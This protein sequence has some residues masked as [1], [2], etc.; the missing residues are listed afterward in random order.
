MLTLLSL[1]L[2]HYSSAEYQMCSW[3][4]EWKCPMA[5]ASLEVLTNSESIQ[6]QIDLLV[7]D[8]CPQ[9]TIMT[10]E[11]CVERLPDFWRSA[12]MFLW[13]AFFGPAFCPDLANC[14][15]MDMASKE[16]MTCELCLADMNNT[17]DTLIEDIDT[18]A[19]FMA[20]DDFCYSGEFPGEE[21]LCVASIRGLLP[22]SL[23]SIPDV[24]REGFPKLC[25]QVFSVCDMI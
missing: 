3:P 13:N 9:V 12:G 14:P 17:I 15:T 4:A 25:N 5:A 6:R 10:P 20:G 24:C 8:V 1:L 21:E 22:L 16:E 19:D 2:I 11:E 7:A 18:I 23:L